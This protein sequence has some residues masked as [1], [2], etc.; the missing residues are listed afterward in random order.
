MKK[1]LSIIWI[2]VF[3]L[4][5]FYVL[6]V[7]ITSEVYSKTTKIES[8]IRSEYLSQFVEMNKKIE[9]LQ[10]L[11]NDNKVNISE[12]KKN[13]IVKSEEV[14]KKN[15]IILKEVLKTWDKKSCDNIVWKDKQV[16]CRNNVYYQDALKKLDENL[17]DKIVNN[18]HDKEVCKIKVWVLQNR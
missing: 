6:Q 8:K 9:D 2:I 10:K 12:I 4:G 14:I 17:C 11:L 13:N 16:L 3:L 15:N 1:L 7:Q 5:Y 18:A